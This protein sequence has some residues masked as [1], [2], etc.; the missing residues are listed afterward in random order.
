MAASWWKVRGEGTLPEVSMS[1]HSLFDTLYS[2]RSLNF[3][4]CWLM[5]PK[6]K[7]LL[8][9]LQDEWRYRARGRAPEAVFSRYQ[10][11]E[12]VEGGLPKLN[13]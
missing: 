13:W 1:D 12:T 10:K 4:W 8:P 11:L 6:M 5:P 7:M 2:C 3:F 9:I